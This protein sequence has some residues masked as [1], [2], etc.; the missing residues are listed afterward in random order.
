MFTAGDFVTFIHSKGLI[1]LLDEFA[2][3]HTV[4][5][6][7]IMKKNFHEA[8]SIW[9]GHAVRAVTHFSDFKKHKRMRLALCLRGHIFVPKLATRFSG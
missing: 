4:L 6:F 9:M 7:A 2:K 1:K 5:A 3:G 8:L